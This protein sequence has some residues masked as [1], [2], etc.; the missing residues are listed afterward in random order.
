MLSRVSLLLTVLVFIHF[1]RAVQSAE[2]ILRG[3]Y[4]GG[5]YGLGDAR[6]RFF[7]FTFQ[8]VLNQDQIRD[9]AG[10][11]VRK[12]EDEGTTARLESFSKF[13]PRG[14][15]RGGDRHWMEKGAILV[16]GWVD[17]DGDR[18][19][20][21]AADSDGEWPDSRHRWLSTGGNSGVLRGLGEEHG[22]PRSDKEVRQFFQ[23]GTTKE[24]QIYLS[25]YVDENRLVWWMG[26]RD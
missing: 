18:W 12:L 9:A 8:G 15:S 10:K 3:T 13:E 7:V 5:T 19:G 21:L 14:Q 11:V 1:D 22:I 4:E 2:P 24:S 16:L 26:L 17:R 20:W 6:V 23:P 25:F